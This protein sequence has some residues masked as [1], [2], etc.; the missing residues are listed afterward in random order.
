MLGISDVTYTFDI[1]VRSCFRNDKQFAAR[2]ATDEQSSVIR[3][4]KPDRTD[5]C[6]RAACE[7]GCLNE[8]RITGRRGR[9]RNRI[10]VRE[11]DPAIPT[12]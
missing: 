2:I 7:I 6:S 5:A 4:R 11:R 9:R 8:E 10:Q 1:V 12:M 3:K